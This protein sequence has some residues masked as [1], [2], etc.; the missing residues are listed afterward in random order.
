M[1]LG[2]P[3]H[4]TNLAPRRARSLQQLGVG[5]KACGRR[6]A[7]SISGRCKISR[8]LRKRLECG[9]AIGPPGR[10]LGRAGEGRSEEVDGKYE[11]VVWQ[12]GVVIQ[13][14]SLPAQLFFFFPPLLLKKPTTNSSSPVARSPAHARP[15]AARATFPG[16][17]TLE[18]V[19]SDAMQAVMSLAELLGPVCFGCSHTSNPPGIPLLVATPPLPQG[20]LCPAHPTYPLPQPPCQP[21]SE[22][23]RVWLERCS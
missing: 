23:C 4:R 17:F 10:G 11:G 21:H 18:M 20:P 5:Q 3:H 1:A 6:S 22:G 7:R 15:L 14:P 13:F 9:A 2:S 16:N 12:R 8:N 19:R